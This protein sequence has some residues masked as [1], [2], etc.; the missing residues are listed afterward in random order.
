MTKDLKDLI[1]KVWRESLATII[2]LLF[3]GL[4]LGYIP[5]ETT[6]TADA[7]RD[8]MVLHR[9]DMQTIGDRNRDAMIMFNKENA[10]YLRKICR[11]LSRTLSELTDCD[12]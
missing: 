3:A 2:A 8:I 11:R 4:Y 9:S 5:N 1:V 6:R 7:A 10:K 12:Q